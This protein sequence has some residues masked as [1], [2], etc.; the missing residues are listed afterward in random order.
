MLLDFA[1]VY[2]QLIEGFSR[3]V[4]P[5]ILILKTTAPSVSARLVCTSAN[6]NELD[7]DNGGG[8]GGVRID[9]K[10]AN[11]LSFIKKISSKVG[12]LTFKAI[13]AFI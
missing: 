5:L 13:L 8:I 9:D 4:A 10:M 12:F 6:K 2:K 3:I 1:N 11:L 7:T